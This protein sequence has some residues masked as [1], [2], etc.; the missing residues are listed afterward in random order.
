MAKLSVDQRIQKVNENI[1][2]EEE[3]IETSKAKIKAFSKQLKALN[4]EKDKQYANDFLHILS[5]NGFTSDDDK[6]QFMQMIKEQFKKT[7][8]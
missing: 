6:T 1:K 8:T 2:K 3:N 4:E 7:N 5:E